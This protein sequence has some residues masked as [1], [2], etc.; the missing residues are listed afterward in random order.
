[1]SQA[2]ANKVHL[3]QVYSIEKSIVLISSEKLNKNSNKK[4]RNAKIFLYNKNI[5]HYLLFVSHYQILSIILVK[6]DILEK[7]LIPEEFFFLHPRIEQLN[8]HVFASSR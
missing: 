2:A 7:S 1:M 4:K 6:F 8:Y 3:A 5:N